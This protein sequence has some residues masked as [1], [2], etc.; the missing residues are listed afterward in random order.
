VKKAVSRIL[1]S[2]KRKEAIIYLGIVLLLS[3]SSLPKYYLHEQCSYQRVDKVFLFGFAPYGVYTATIV[4]NCAVS[5]YLTISPLPF[6]K[7]GILSVALSVNFDLCHCC[8]V[9]NRH[10]VLWSSDFPQ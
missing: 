1:S 6:K 8:P 3:S 4:A 9:I 5:S 7:G 2:S 10:T